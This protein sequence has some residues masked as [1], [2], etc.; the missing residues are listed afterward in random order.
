[1]VGVTTLLL[2][3]AGLL[4]GLLAVIWAGGSILIRRRWGA[5]YVLTVLGATGGMLAGLAPLWV[6]AGAA[7][8]IVL[9][10]GWALR[11]V[12]APAR[13]SS[14][15]WARAVEAGAIGAAL[16]LMLVL[17][18]TISWTEGAVPA[19]FLLPSAVA[20]FW[21][22]YHLRLLEQAI[23]G[24]VSGI[25]AGDAPHG[26]R[27]WGPLSVLAGAMGRL[28]LAAGALSMALLLMTPWLG[29][30]ARSAGV[31]GGFALLALATLLVGLL[32]AL[33]H[34]RWALIAAACA[35]A[36]E[37]L[38]AVAVSEPSPGTGLVVGG[39][40]AIALMLP[41]AVGLLIRP[42][43]TLATALWIP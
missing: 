17:D 13:R 29:S 1:L 10:V 40:V 20:S 38:V 16:G 35:V 19:L 36:A 21:G 3:L 27:A 24:A 15:P 11:A 23:P 5:A 4:A 18:R 8:A 37:E 26:G 34:G 6:L 28:V 43:G 12:A 30:G 33:G 31:L 9:T 7:T 42:A 41:V 14:V 2:G 22:G 32:D 25:P 39:A